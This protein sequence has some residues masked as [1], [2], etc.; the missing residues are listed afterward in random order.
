MIFNYENAAMILSFLTE[1]VFPFFFF[2]DGSSEPPREVLRP[3]SVPVQDERV[4]IIRDPGDIQMQD[5]H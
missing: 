5:L 4:G 2:Q 3:I 1:K